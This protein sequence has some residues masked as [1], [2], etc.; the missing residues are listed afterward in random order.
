MAQ[1]HPKFKT[2]LLE[3]EPGSVIFHYSV[4]NLDGS[5]M[6]KEHYVLVTE[7]LRSHID[8]SGGFRVGTSVYPVMRHPIL[9]LEGTEGIIYIGI[10]IIP[11]SSFVTLNIF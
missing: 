10:L 3:T 7:Q 1:L 4:S 11:F 6:T 5:D 2:E 9:H 8:T